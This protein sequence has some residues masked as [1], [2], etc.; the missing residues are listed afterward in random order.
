MHATLPLFPFLLAGLACS[1][2]H[3][4]HVPSEKVKKTQIFF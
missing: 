4:L 3:F 2:R 1:K